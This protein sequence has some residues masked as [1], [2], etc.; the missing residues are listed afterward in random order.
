MQARRGSAEPHGCLECMKR[1]TSSQRPVRSKPPAGVRIDLGR[2]N[3][4]LMTV[5][6]KDRIPW[7]ACEEAHRLLVHIWRSD[8]TAWLVSNYVLMPDHL[9]LFAA[10][11][12]LSFTIEKWLA[13]WKSQFTKGHAHRDWAWQS[14]SLHHRLRCEESYS[15]KWLYMQENPVR[16]G[17]VSKSSLWP[18]QGIVH[19]LRW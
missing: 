2:L 15:Q 7:L 17:L 10:P 18:Y 11:R 12:D 6:T 3:F 14:N 4:V 13:Y 1:S 16:A 19:D 8:A 9:H 5:C